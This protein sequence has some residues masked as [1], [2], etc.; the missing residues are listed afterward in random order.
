[1][2]RE[3]V[4]EKV[5]KI[6][7]RAE[8]SDHQGEVDAALALASRL[9]AQHAIEQAEVDALKDSGEPEK[10]IERVVIVGADKSP[11]SR[12][13]GNL[14]VAVAQYN[15]CRVFK[16]TRLD[17]SGAQW[18]D[19]YALHIIGYE[20]DVDYMEMLWTSLCLQMDEAHNR[21]KHNRPS[22]VH[23]RTFRT[24]F[25]IGFINEAWQ[26]L[27]TIQEQTMADVREESGSSTALV[28]VDREKSVDDYMAQNHRNLRSGRRSSSRRDYHA[29]QSGRVAAGRADYSGGRTKR[30]AARQALGN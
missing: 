30:F 14:A 27:K 8:G 23:A 26:R 13:K 1:M 12:S 15:R 16:T 18:R 19:M 4:L 3:S 9:M 6:L 17:T 10:I 2:S 24:S 29:E 25:C 20:S 7:D 21:A 11:I 5:R 28:L 22:W